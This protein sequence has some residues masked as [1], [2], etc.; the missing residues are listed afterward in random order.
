MEIATDG[1]VAMN[2]TQL[3]MRGIDLLL[4][5][6]H[7]FNTGPMPISWPRRIRGAVEHRWLRPAVFA[8]NIDRGLFQRKIYA[9]AAG[10]GGVDHL[11][12]PHVQ[13]WS[14]SRKEDVAIVLRDRPDDIPFPIGVKD[15]EIGIHA[16]LG[17]VGQRPETGKT[18]INARHGRR[19]SLRSSAERKSATQRQGQELGEL[20]RFR[21]PETRRRVHRLR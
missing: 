4:G 3:Q 17:T 20:R 5:V 15:V 16:S 11:A 2:D 21:R 18:D 12:R 14:G 10:N 1:A 13:M 6:D 19:G 9:N 7:S 8:E